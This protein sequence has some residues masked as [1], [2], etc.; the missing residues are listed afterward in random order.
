MKKSKKIAS[1]ASRKWFWLSIIEQFAGTV[2][3]V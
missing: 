3:P 1:L 2:E